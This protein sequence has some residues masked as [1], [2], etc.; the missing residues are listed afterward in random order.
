MLVA[1]TGGSGFLGAHLVRRLLVRGDRVRVLVRPGGDRSN[2]AGLPVETV[3]GVLGEGPLGAGFP[4]PADLLIHLAAV[5]PGQG[6]DEAALVRVNVAGTAAVLEAARRDRV[7]RLL[8]VSTMGTCAPAPGGRSATEADRPAVSRLSPYARSKLSA[9]DLALGFPGLEVVAALPAAPV[10][11]WDR[12][13]TVTGARVRA[14]LGGRWPDLPPGLVNH[15][16]AA[17]CAQGLLLVAAGGRPGARYLLGGEN[18][19][20]R[21]FV[22]RV[23]AAG[24]VPV[25][26][27][28][29]SDRLRRWRPARRAGL[30]I[31]DRRAREELGYRPGDLDTAFREAAAWFRD[32]TTPAAAPGAGA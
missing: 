11:A 29:L 20:P 3:D 10:G 9:E 2:L 14:V 18:L 8:H 24:G 13:P 32:G 4:G 28:P 26:G 16:P 1:V 23:A 17:G 15:V 12:R 22:E 30:A 6:A 31:D 7:P 19:A 21:A 27:R 5:L 25:P